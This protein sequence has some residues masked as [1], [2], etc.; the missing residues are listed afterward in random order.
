MYISMIVRSLF[1]R[2]RMSAPSIIF[3]DEVDALVGSRGIGEGG[4]GGGSDPVRDRIL[5]TLLNEMDGIEM[6]K[7]ILVMVRRSH[8]SVSFWISF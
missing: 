5:S 6:A 3:L 8:F 2:A 4:S 7:G 1:S